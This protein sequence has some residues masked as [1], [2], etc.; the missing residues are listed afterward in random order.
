MPQIDAVP[1]FEVAGRAAGLS[2][3]ESARRPHRSS[4]PD[5]DSYGV[6][7]GDADSDDFFFYLDTFVN[8]DLTV[9]DIDQDA[10]CDTEDF[11]AY[12]DLFAA[13]C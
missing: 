7:D 11:F 3:R 13:G 1:D 8:G 10:D 9:C 2:G 6:P 4:D 5:D 12:L